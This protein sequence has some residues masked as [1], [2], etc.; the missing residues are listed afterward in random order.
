MPV[1]C[2]DFPPV[3]GIMCSLFAAFRQ[4]ATTQALGNDKQMAGS[5]WVAVLYSNHT[6][7]CK[8]VVFQRKIYYWLQRIII[9]ITFILPWCITNFKDIY[10]MLLGEE[11]SE[12]HQAYKRGHLDI[13]I[14]NEIRTANI[15][16]KRVSIHF[17]ET[18]D[19]LKVNSAK[20][21]PGVSMD[22]KITLWVTS[23]VYTWIP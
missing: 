8:I 17:I 19:R 6:D 4:N 14:L 10:S 13:T 21:V 3:V 9:I 15:W 1:S 23:T 11:T 20:P 5:R 16:C 18:F 12:N 7:V 22:T 2:P